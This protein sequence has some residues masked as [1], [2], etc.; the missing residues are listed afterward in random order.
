MFN[1]LFFFL[2]YHF[3]TYMNINLNLNTMGYIINFYG[4]GTLID[5][6]IVSEIT[7]LSVDELK[8]SPSYISEDD[9]IEQIEVYIDRQGADQ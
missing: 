4:E 5:V 9:V 7:G 6:H 2:S 3:I 8:S 1:L